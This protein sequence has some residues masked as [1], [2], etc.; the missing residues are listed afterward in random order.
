MEDVLLHYQPGR[1]DSVSSLLETTEKLLEP[2]HWRPPSVFTPWF[3]P[4]GDCHPPIRPARPPPVIR[5]TGQ[6]LEYP[7]TQPDLSEFGP[8]RPQT[9]ED[10]DDLPTPEHR[11]RPHAEARNHRAAATE[12]Q[13]TK[14]KVSVLVDER[15]HDGPLTQSTRK[16][17]TENQQ[18][19]KDDDVCMSETPNRPH[20]AAR[21][22]REERDVARAAP[23]SPLRRSWSIFALTGVSL[24]SPLS[25]SKLFHHVVST[26]RLHL[27]QRAKWVV[28]QQNCGTG[29]DIEQVWRCLNRAVRSS[30]L[31]TCNANIQREQ[32]EIWVFCDLLY[33]ELVGRFLKDELRLCGSIHLCV[34]RRGNVFSM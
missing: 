12:L 23:G 33:S 16:S 21:S 30:G 24:P 20:P 34:H 4:A 28:R 10:R 29:R 31:P 18:T 7:G 22:D 19:S 32:E 9:R 5:D 25:L 17:T 13:Q 26:H 14:P 6:F 15:P 3:P 8:Q 2:F 1:G 11:P 27:R